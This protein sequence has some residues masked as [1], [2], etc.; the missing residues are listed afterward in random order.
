MRKLHTTK[1]KSCIVLCSIVIKTTS[2]RYIILECV[3]IMNVLVFPVHYF[4]F[5]SLQA[6][7]ILY[8]Q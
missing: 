3:F 5:A 4:A 1:R 6:K 7:F 8:I 2:T